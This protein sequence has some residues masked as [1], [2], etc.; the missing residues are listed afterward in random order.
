MSFCAKCQKRRNDTGRN[1]T[2]G[3]G[4]IKYDRGNSHS[5]LNAGEMNVRVGL[6]RANVPVSAFVSIV[7]RT[8][9]NIKK[10]ENRPPSLRVHDS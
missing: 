10:L 5:S 1:P 4:N 6:F 3:E 2:Y 7:R 9:R 8:S